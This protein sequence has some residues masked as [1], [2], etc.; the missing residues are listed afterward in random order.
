M[1]FEINFILIN[2][3]DKA[4]K[5]WKVTGREKGVTQKIQTPEKQSDKPNQKRENGPKWRE[6]RKDGNLKRNVNICC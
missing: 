2:E 3:K 1:Y 6:D 4:R 5:N